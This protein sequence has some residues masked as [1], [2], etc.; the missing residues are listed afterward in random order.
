[1]PLSVSPT[2]RCSTSATYSYSADGLT[3]TIIPARPLAANS[4]AV[5]V[6]GIGDAPVHLLLHR[7]RRRAEYSGCPRQFPPT[8]P[9]PR[10]L[11]C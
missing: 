5:T 6:K 8:G 10:W 9:I 7:S 2:L 1:M 3:L 4:E 11:P